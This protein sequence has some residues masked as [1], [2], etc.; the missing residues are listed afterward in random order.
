MSWWLWTVVG[1]LLLAAEV[2]FP[3]GFFLFIFGIGALTVAFCVWLGVAD[4]MW[5][6]LCIMA[7]SS[8]LQAVFFRKHMMKMIVS[9][10]KGSGSE[11]VGSEV[12]V[13]EEIEVHGEGK[14][15]LSGAMWRVKNIGSSPLKSGKRYRVEQVDGLT[16]CVS[17]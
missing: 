14:G 16:L 3:T 6:Q 12:L 11:I 5:I 15:E 8:V 17:G 7:G 10:S 13:L 4:L 1:F 9:N 2:F